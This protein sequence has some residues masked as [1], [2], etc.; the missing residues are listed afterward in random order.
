LNGVIV[1]VFH[2]TLSLQGT[3]AYKGGSE[4]Q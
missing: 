1:I 2:N 3:V 4:Q